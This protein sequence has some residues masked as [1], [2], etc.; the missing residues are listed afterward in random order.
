MKIQ[1]LIESDAE[2]KERKAFLNNWEELSF[3]ESEFTT[4]DGE[5]VL[6]V[7]VGDEEFEKLV[8]IFS[9]PQE[10]MGAF[11]TSA[12]EHG[13]E[14][15]PTSYVVYHADF[16]GNKVIAGIKTPQGISLHDQLHLEQMIQNMM[17]FPR[18]IVYSSDVLTFIKD[19][20]PEVDSRAYII[21]REIARKGF[22]APS[23]ED[24]GKVYGMDLSKLE[25]KLEL[26][27]K[28]ILEPV[29]LPDGELNLRPYDLP[30]R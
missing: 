3:S 1:V 4:E 14:E 30:L 8:G 19:L 5:R 25:G 26:I 24:L 18:V 29:R 7:E 16:D 17:R 15:V 11:L 21:A 28:L 22:R 27:E 20:Y 13:W 9:S 12:Q 2:A 23:L 6:R 10:A